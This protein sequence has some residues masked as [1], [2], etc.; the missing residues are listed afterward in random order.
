MEELAE[1]VM[2]SFWEKYD[3]NHTVI[4]LATSWATT[5]EDLEKLAQVL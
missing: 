2:F 4:R 5:D 3:D 1:D